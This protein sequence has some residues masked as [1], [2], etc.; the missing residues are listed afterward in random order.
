MTD[1]VVCDF[2]WLHVDQPAKKSEILA[3]CHD[4]RFVVTAGETVTNATVFMDSRLVNFSKPV[5]VELNGS[6]TS[7][8]FAPDLKV[9]CETLARRADPGFAFSAAFR[10]M[11]DPNTAR[12]V[13]VPITPQ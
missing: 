8:Q 5:D 12:L 13:V 4:N 6:T 11:K 9:F 1:K 10:V 3:S 7:R 2:F